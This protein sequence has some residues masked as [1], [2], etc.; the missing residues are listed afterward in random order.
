MA[1]SKEYLDFILEQ[2]SELEEITYRAMM[3]EYIIYYNGK[4]IGGIYDDRLLVK[5]VQAAINYMPNAKYE[6][7][8][9]GA[10]EMLLVDDVDNKKFLTG[11]FN[12]MYYELPAPKPKK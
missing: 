9:D 8:Y 2:L 10:K 7:P 11:L 12:S 1:S 4:I 3:G 6:L 5:P